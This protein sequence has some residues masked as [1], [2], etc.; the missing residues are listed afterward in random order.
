MVRCP[1]CKKELSTPT[2]TWKY[3]AFTVQSYLCD[4][5]NMQLRDYTK[6]GKHVFSLVHIQGSLWKKV[7]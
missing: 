4:K 1:K 2:K 5:C 7:E 6:E 3:N